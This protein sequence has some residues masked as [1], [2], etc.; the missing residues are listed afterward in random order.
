[1]ESGGNRRKSETRQRQRVR[2]VRFDRTEDAALESAASKAGLS[3]AAFVR[4]RT[5]G[6]A[7]D[8][9]LRKRIDLAELGR[10][11]AE[12]G[13]IGSNINQLARVANSNGDLPTA[14]RL[15]EIWRELNGI[16]SE[17]MRALGRGD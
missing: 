17:L 5:L 8:R 10:L 4:E 9:S 6:R 16:R 11:L 2:H 3:V 13:K 14:D 7:G 15:D 1:L 12:T